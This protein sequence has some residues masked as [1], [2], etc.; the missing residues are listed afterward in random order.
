MVADP[1]QHLR[2][3]QEHLARA[4][5]RHQV[6]LALAVADVGV[7]DA[8]EEVRRVAERLRQ[9]DALAD[10][11]RQLAPFGHV[12]VALDADDVADVEVLDPVEGLLAERVDP[13][14]GL[15]RP[16][17]VADVEEGRLAVAALPGHPTGDPVGELL[18]LP[19]PQRLG[20]VGLEDRLDPV[21]LA[22]VAREGVDPFAAQALGLRLALGPGGTVGQGFTPT[23]TRSPPM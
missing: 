6:E 11:D 18:V 12:E 9:Q 20:V 2:P 13:G 7:G 22:E 16:G 5:V 4:L 1:R 15:D 21:A 23:V 17:E 19:L 8:V 3:G 10:L 14:V